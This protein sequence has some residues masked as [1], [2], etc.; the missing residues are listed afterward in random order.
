LKLDDVLR[1]RLLRA[2]KSEKKQCG[3]GLQPAAD[4]QSASRGVRF[5]A[6]RPIENR[7]QVANLPHNSMQEWMHGQNLT[8]RFAFIVRMAL[9]AF[10]NPN[11]ALVTVV[12]QLGK[13][14]WL[15]ALVASNRKS[16]LP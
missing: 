2:E 3:A 6:S 10:G 5:I 9:A 11:W 14:T 12:F 4:F 15:S 13:V 16:M 7:P 1:Q 8:L